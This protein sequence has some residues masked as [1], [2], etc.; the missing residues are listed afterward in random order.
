MAYEIRSV[1]NVEIELSKIMK[2][3]KAL[4]AQILK[5]IAKIAEDPHN[6]GKWMHN[7]YAGVKEVHLFHGRFVLMFKIDDEQKVVSIIN[8]EHHPE[9]HGY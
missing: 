2:R 8:I 9:S 4:Y 6:T 3:D 7:I 5:K 1:E